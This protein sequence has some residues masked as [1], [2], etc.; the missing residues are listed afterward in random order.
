[1]SSSDLSRLG[2]PELHVHHDKLR[3]LERGE[4]HQQVCPSLVDVVLGRGLPV[5]FEEVRVILARALERT[6]S[7]QAAE[8][9]PDNHAV[10]TAGTFNTRDDQTYY[11]I[12]KDTFSSLP[13]VATDAE[14]ILALKPS[15]II[16]SM[17]ADAATANDLQTKTGIPVYV[18]NANLE[19]GENFYK[20]ISSLGTLFGEEKRAAELNKGIADLIGDITAKALINS[21]ATAYACGM[22]YY[23]GASLLKASGNYL[24]FDYSNLSNAITP[25][26]NGQPYVITLETLIAANPDYFFIDSIGLSGCIAS[27]EAAVDTTPNSPIVLSI[28]A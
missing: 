23:G 13:Q 5:A 6:L 10:E 20:Q 25:A 16:T 24:P 11:L 18:I 3:R 2:R 15:I 1:M 22:F 9:L 8:E 17:A 12:N 27:M 28:T 21:S 4:P 26:E 19:F 7:E 14:S